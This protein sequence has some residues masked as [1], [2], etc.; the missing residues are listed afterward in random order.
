[1]HFIKDPSDELVGVV[2]LVVVEKLIGLLNRCDKLFV[3]EDTFRFFLSVY[4]LE[5]VLNFE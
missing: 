4:I 1:V 3:I 5:E 2:V